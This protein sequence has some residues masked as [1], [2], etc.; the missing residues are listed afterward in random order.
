MGFYEYLKMMH[1]S[2]TLK[3]G[4]SVLDG[5]REAF[6]GI[7]RT[8]EQTCHNLDVMHIENNFFDNSF[9]TLMCVLGKTSIILRHVKI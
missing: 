6:F 8:E 1:L 3:S 9:N 4:T 5:R 2:T 7:Y